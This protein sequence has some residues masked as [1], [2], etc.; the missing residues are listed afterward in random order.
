MWGGRVAV[1]MGLTATLA[2]GVA[3]TVHAQ[4][5]TRDAGDI[6]I[7]EHDGS[8]YDSH[9]EGGELNV[10]ARD[11]VGQRFFETHGDDYDFLVVFTN[12]DFETKDATAFHLGARNSVSGI[13]KP[14][15]AVAPVVF[16]SPA[17]L[18]GWIDM[19]LVDQ[20]RAADPSPSPRGSWAF[21]RR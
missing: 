17:R 1:L 2:L 3:A 10:D 20:Y 13:G 12:F 11:W 9:L 18:Q 5:L 15:G 16:G 8:N 14:L 7:V 21:C 4:G 19:A 6:A